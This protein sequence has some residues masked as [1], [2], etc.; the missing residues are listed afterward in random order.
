MI[1][2]SF[3]PEWSVE[4]CKRNYYLFLKNSIKILHHIFKTDIIQKNGTRQKKYIYKGK[5]N[6]IPIQR[7]VINHRKYL[8][9]FPFFTLP[10]SLLLLQD[11]L[12]D[13][14]FCHSLFLSWCK[15][16][17]LDFLEKKGFILY[18]KM[19]KYSIYRSE[20]KVVPFSSGKGTHSPP[21]T[22]KYVYLIFLYSSA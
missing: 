13:S 3:N 20:K 4:A 7:F 5:K 2:I 11:N 19:E 12:L 22:K 16:V 18:E 15:R 17:N 21:T 9:V 6:S 1:Y 14:V 10:N 8:D